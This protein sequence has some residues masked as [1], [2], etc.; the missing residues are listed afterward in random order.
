M[1]QRDRKGVSDTAMENK[2][3]PG[4]EGEGDRGREGP[5][6]LDSDNGSECGRKAGLSDDREETV[7]R[8]ELM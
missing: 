8:G 7:S 1:F 4:L 2:I 6:P 3:E 5:G